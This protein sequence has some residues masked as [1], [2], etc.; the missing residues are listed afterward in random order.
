[1]A[2]RPVEDATAA[3]VEPAAT[4]PP[5]AT[6]T[7]A[8]A[9]TAPATTGPATTGPATTGPATTGPATTAPATTGPAPPVSA[10]AVAQGARRGRR[11]GGRRAGGR[12]A[13]ADH[14]TT[15]SGPARPHPDGTTGTGGGTGVVVAQ[16][17]VDLRTK[18]LLARV[19][20]GE[21][22]VVDHEDLDRLAAE[23]LIRARVGAVVNAS[24][25]ISGRYPNVGPLLLAAA[26][27]PLIDEV[28][29][30]I[31]VAVTEGQWLRVAGTQVLR[32]TEVVASGTRHTLESL[33]SQLEAAKRS[34][35]DELG[36]FAEN[37]LSYLA[38][39]HHLLIDSPVLPDLRT[40]LAGRH[41][42]VVVRGLD[43]R[44]D[45]AA[46][47]SYIRELR[48]VL[49]G[50]DGGADAL[51]EA[52]H[53]PDLIIGDFDSVS[54]TA[55]RGGAQ[56]VVHA[57]PGG[58]APGAERLAALGLP[59]TRF[60]ATGTSEDVAMLLAYEKRAELIVA[61]GTHASMV[62]FLDKGREGMASTFLV[63]LKVGPILV[64]AKGVNRLYQS[65]VRRGDLVVLV[66][67]ALLAMLVI[68]AVAQPLHVFIRA[69]GLSLHDTW[70]ALTGH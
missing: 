11:A 68:V 43:Y 15:A 29:P 22:A 13:G 8:P 34:V 30:Q 44:D 26:G 42:L 2:R 58:D 47:R 59:F 70:H 23:G 57:Y 53:S 31:M 36:R 1:M 69:M 25:S 17:R 55:L 63:R 9:T 19:Q 48:P 32:G 65:R 64:D 27:I 56:L 12:T 67:A 46:L 10:A 28:G 45:L 50:V 20:P 39:E 38:R 5:A 21:V 6:A 33:E 24:R 62:E 66:A 7:T 52:G 60:E 3:A 16:A 18:S 61:V 51:L 14:A 54:D 35:S 41:V 40:D 49:V 4:A 37:T